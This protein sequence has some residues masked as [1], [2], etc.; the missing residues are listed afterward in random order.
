MYLTFF[1]NFISELHKYGG[2]LVDIDSRDAAATPDS[3]QAVVSAK[4]PAETAAASTTVLPHA[5][6]YHLG[7]QAQRSTIAGQRS[8]Q[9]Q[10]PIQKWKGPDKISRIYG[11][12]IDETE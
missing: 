1:M 3:K 7:V 6:V 4:A 2:G 8:G 11:D 9:V 12:W 5:D 10:R